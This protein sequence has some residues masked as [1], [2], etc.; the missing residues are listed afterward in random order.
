MKQVREVSNLWCIFWTCFMSI[1][2]ISVT[3]FCKS[4]VFEFTKVKHVVPA[5]TEYVPWFGKQLVKPL[6]HCHG[7]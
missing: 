1:T 5:L 2:S 4:L 6:W 3:V 7:E